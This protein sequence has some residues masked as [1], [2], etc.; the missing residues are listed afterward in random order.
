[1]TPA[2]FQRLTE[3]IAAHTGASLDD[4]GEAAARIGDMVPPVDGRG[5]WRIT[6][7]GSAH[8]IPPFA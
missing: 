2:D 6:V 3:W 7:A 8:T 4:A 1:M 5:Y